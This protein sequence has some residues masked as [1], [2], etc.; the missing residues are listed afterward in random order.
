M[1]A[2]TKFNLVELLQVTVII[3]VVVTFTY[4]L[5]KFA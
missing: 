2:P 5:D 4:L 3:A 1:H